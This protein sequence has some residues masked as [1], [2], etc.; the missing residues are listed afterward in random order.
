MEIIDC[1]KKDFCPGTLSKT[2]D[3]FDCFS[4]SE[5][6]DL[7]GAS[8]DNEFVPAVGNKTSCSGW[9][10]RKSQ[11]L[12]LDSRLGSISTGLA[13]KDRLS[14]TGAEEAGVVSMVSAGKGW[15]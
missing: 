2:S 4:C 11:I 8:F 3:V 5:P 15:S 9:L 14:A 10:K 7:T 1:G 6:G 12:A 13:D